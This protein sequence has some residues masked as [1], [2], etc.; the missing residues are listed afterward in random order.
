MSELLT[1]AKVRK[2]TDK[3]LEHF[4]WSGSYPFDWTPDCKRCLI[5]HLNMPLNCTKISH[6][7][8]KE[9]LP[10]WP[11][12]PRALIPYIRENLVKLFAL[13]RKYARFYKKEK[14]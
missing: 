3:E 6:G 8:I 5:E 11:D 7:V 2:M 10:A 13:R 4:W 14:A 1:V 9:E 12:G